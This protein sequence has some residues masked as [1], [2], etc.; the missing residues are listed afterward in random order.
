MFRTQQVLGHI[1]SLTL[2]GLVQTT[3]RVIK[4]YHLH[5]HLILQQPEVLL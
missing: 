4:Q 1:G 2:H 3:K 5:L